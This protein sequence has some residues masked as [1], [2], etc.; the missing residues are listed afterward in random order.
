MRGTYILLAL[1]AC[2]LFTACS[3]KKV[4]SP[5]QSDTPFPITVQLDW[6][7]EPEHGAFYTAEA[8][9]YY[10]AEGLDV[11]LLQGGANAYV[12]TKVATNQAQIGQDDSGDILTSIQSGVPLL[13]VGSIFQ[14]DPSV[15]MMHASN[16]IK[17]WSDLNG[18]TIM[19]KISWT[20]LPF[21][22]K[23]Y[24]IEYKVI[25][26]DYNLGR[27]AIDPDFIQ[28]AYFTSEPYYL[29]QKG[30]KTKFLH[31]ADA[32]FDSYTTIMTNKAFAKS[33]PEQLKAFLRATYKGWKTYIELDG[34]AAHAIM[35]KVNPKVTPSFLDWC[36][37]QIIKA[38]L[39]KD[40][41]D[42]YLTLSKKRFQIQID[43]L[44]DLGI[45]KK[46]AV[47]VEDAVDTSFLPQANP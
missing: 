22:R 35:L 29:E 20:F 7:A 33:H 12:Q 15:L 3:N 42:D 4:I 2:S 34:A 24:G 9:G 18:K 46:D 10:K 13:C 41:K 19:S 40:A 31:A 43:Q 45:L 5:V 27:F 6:V 25:P 44:T 32:G 11:T 21:L 28:Q 26:M 14:H 8:L 38:E 1:I 16:P 17:N 39:A 47:K 37:L 36:R 30:I 23:K